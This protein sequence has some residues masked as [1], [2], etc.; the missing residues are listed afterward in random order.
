[1][2]DLKGKHAIVTGGGTGIGRSI[3][4]HLAK[5]GCNLILTGLGNED[6]L[7]VKEECEKLGV[8]AW[9][10]E[11]RLD[12][13]GSI[14]EFHDFVMGLGV[15]VDLFVLNA[16]ISQR[17]KALDTDFSVDEKILKV[18]FM[19]GVYM[20]K[21][22]GDMIKAAEHVQFSVTTSLSGLFGFPLRSAYCAAKH[23]LFG[24]YES[25]ELEYPN[26]NVTFLIPGRI[27]TQISKSALMGDGTAHAKMD[28]G[29][30]NGLDVDK[31][32]AIAVKAIKRQKHRKLIGKTELLMAHIH[33][34][35]LP[36]Y[37]R[38]SKRISAT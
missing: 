15:T 6:L 1:M 3:S 26:I 32:G 36:L 4:I 11:T 5:E 20:V 16:G 27:N 17:E 14:D 35:C 30:A 13:Y 24:F 22:F 9:A 37:Y 2:L 21:K 34:W 7:K 12:D 28:A 25:L 23:A 18:D 8:K 33:K 10:K 31:C 38:L 29:Q 19:S